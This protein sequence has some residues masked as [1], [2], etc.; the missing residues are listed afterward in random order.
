M[1]LKSAR[2]QLFFEVVCNLEKLQV[3]SGEAETEGRGL[4]GQL[5]AI[6]YRS[7]LKWNFNPGN[8]A[9]NRVYRF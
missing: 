2:L 8:L 4:L 3:V 6:S 9:A 1:R 5:G 7:S